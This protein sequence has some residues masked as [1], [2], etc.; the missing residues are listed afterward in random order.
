MPEW[1]DGAEIHEAVVAEVKKNQHSRKFQTCLPTLY[2]LHTKIFN[3]F[4]GCAHTFVVVRLSA[5]RLG[6]H[7]VGLKAQLLADGG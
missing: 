5:I 6:F 1:K 7:D 2:T 3:L 4:R